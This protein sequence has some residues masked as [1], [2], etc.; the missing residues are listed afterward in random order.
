[1]SMAVHLSS[2]RLISSIH[3]RSEPTQDPTEAQ[4]E[5]LEDLRAWHKDVDRQ[6]RKL[7]ASR[8]AQRGLRPDDLCLQAPEAPMTADQKLFIE[9]QQTTRLMPVPSMWESKTPPPPK[10]WIG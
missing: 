5:S 2:L 10:S 7:D 9:E 8:R 4:H 3:S 1:M 6:M